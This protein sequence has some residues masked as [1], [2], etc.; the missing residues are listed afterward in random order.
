M[1]LTD[2]D[3]IWQHYALQICQDE[4]IAKDLV[5]EMYLKL[6]H[7]E[8]LSKRYVYLT[9]LNDFRNRCNKKKHEISVDDFKYFEN[10]PDD[11]ETLQMRFELIDLLNN[12][13]GW[14]HREVLYHTHNGSLRE[15]EKETGV[16]YGVLNYHKKKAL[17]IIKNKVKNGRTKR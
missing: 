7:H 16:Y 6:L 3:K 1:F 17:K 15:A 14:F 8:S 9:M 12:N 10:I 2:N 4:H 11:E 5:Q 13:L